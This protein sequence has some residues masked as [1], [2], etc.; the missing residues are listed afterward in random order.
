[1]TFLER[2]KD[3]LQ[4]KVAQNEQLEKEI[5]ALDE[6]LTG[7]SPELEALLVEILQKHVAVVAT[8]VAVQAAT[9]TPEDTVAVVVAELAGD[10]DSLDQTGGVV[11]EVT[12]ATQP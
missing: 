1:M 2:V 4:N 8:T 10:S 12:E 3:T 5:A 11:P 6:L 9:P 7:A